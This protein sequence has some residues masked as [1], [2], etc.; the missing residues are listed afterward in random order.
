MEL[1]RLCGGEMSRHRDWLR[2]AGN[3]LEW[4]RYSFAGDYHAQTCFVSDRMGE[5]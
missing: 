2:Q 1:V 4:A 3:D 5:A